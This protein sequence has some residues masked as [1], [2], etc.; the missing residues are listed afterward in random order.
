MLEKD[1]FSKLFTVINPLGVNL[2]LSDKG[3]T[4][5]ANPGINFLLNPTIPRNLRKLLA[6]VGHGKDSISFTLLTVGVI[7]FELILKT[8]KSSDVTLKI[9][10]DSD[11]FRL[12]S[13][14]I[15]KTVSISF[16]R[17]GSSSLKIKMSSKYIKTQSICRK[18]LSMYLWNVADE[19]FNPNGINS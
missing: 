16:L 3:K 8:W 5:F 10:F 9:D 7:P 13:C 14:K 12:F 4:N 11:I 18:I 1:C 19:F 17:E 15:L 6:S 2:I